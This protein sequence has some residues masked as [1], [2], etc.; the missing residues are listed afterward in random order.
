MK[1]IVQRQIDL[2]KKEN[3]TMANIEQIAK[4]VQKM[5]L[6]IGQTV[7]PRESV[8][9][10]VKTEPVEEEESDNSEACAES[11]GE[12]VFTISAKD[13]YTKKKDA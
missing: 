3:M 13:F 8:P 6:E 5:I 9:T 12:D 10:I 7:E 1:N 11:D 2:I 4:K